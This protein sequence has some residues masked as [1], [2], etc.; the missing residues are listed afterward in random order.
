MDFYDILDQVIALLKQR[1]RASYR[2]LKVQFHLDDE[3]LEAL[4]EELLYA[5][6][7]VD[8]QGRGLLWTGDVTGTV[9]APAQPP[10]AIPSPLPQEI[11]PIQPASPSRTSHTPEAERRQLTVLFCDL[12]DSTV[13]AGQLD[14]ED[15]REVIRA[16]QEV[17]AKVIARF[18]GHIAQ[19]LGD[20]LLVYFGYPLA[21]EDDAP[22]AVRTGLGIIE[23]MGQLHPSLGPEREVHLAVRLGIHT[24]LV[25][26]GDVGAGTRHEPLA[27]GETPNIAARLQALAAPNT[28]VISAAT[29]QLIAGYFQ[30]KALGAH[31][32]PGLAQPMEVYRI[33]GASGAQSRLEVAATYGLTPLVGRAQEVGLLMAC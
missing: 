12:V 20:G 31:T 22:R 30:W 5:H 27:L 21:H 8:D 10:Q 7:V 1:G 4:K 9:E 28:L 11:P 15:L 3:S 29:Q 2:A 32:L 16:Y 26:V 23:A 19:Y 25:V 13:L 6:A 33:L 24:G 14:P 17:C 18:E